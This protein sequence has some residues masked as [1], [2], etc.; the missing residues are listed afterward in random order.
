MENKYFNEALSSMVADFAYS[1]AVRH[2]YDN[3]YS[4]EEIHDRLDYPVSVEKIEQVIKDYEASKTGDES[5]FE[6]IQ[7]TDE[8]GRRS[9]IRVDKNKNDL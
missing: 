2:M 9:F 5:N 4:A 7:K 1:K 8:F 3:G 6:Y